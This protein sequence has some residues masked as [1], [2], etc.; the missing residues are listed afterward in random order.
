[1]LSTSVGILNGTSIGGGNYTLDLFFQDGAKAKYLRVGDTVKDKNNN[2]YAVTTWA[3]SPSDFVSGGQVTVSFVTVDV[4][5]AT[6][7]G[8]DS[9]VFT[10]GQVDA[11]PAVKTSGTLSSP[12]VFSGQNF[13]YTVSANWDD[14]VEAS[15][16]VVGDSVVDS[17]GKEF[18]ITFIDPGGFSQPFR[19][20]ESLKEGQAP[21]PGSASLYRSTVNFDLFQGTPI[22]DPARTVVRNRDD[23]NIDAALKSLQD[24]IGSSN[25]GISSSIENN[26][27]QTII[28]STPVRLN[29]FGDIATIDVG[30]EDEA[31]AT[32]GLVSADIADGAS[33]T[34][35]TAG[36]VTDIT[37]TATFDDIM[38]VSKSGSL[39]NVKPDIG[40]SGF[41]AG[42]FVIAVGVIAKNES[43]PSLK[44]LIVNIQTIGQ[45]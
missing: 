39:T 31:L 7:A 12:S 33:G 29:S 10:P 34:I 24:Q 27:G 26:T 2:E 13:E 20:T 40:V 18:E 6:S 15:Q 22:S 19:V 4:A 21:T 3:V 23:F 17:E 1:M 44:D 28:K 5:P 45:L 36:K 25:A 11:R 38:F 43:N 35:V 9:E 41:V 14:G 8:F 42:D 16:A 32:I 37:T 30:V